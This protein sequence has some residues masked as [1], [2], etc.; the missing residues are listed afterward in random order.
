MAVYLYDDDF[1]TIGVEI[2][3]YASNAP[4]L[5]SEGKSWL[6]KLSNSSE[7]LEADNPNCSNTSDK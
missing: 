1:E 5:T 2:P 6:D 3:P 7:T 4:I